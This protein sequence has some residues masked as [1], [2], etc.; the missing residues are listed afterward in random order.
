MMV[1]GELVVGYEEKR[2]LYRNTRFADILKEAEQL[3]CNNEF[4]A[5]SIVLDGLRSKNELLERLNEKIKAKPFFKYLK[6]SLAGKTVNEY[7]ELKAYTSFATHVAIE[8]EK[9]NDEY[10]FL[11]K[12]ILGNI[13][14]LSVSKELLAE[15]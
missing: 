4:N 6:R 10:R 7:E 1:M 8:C 14:E 12:K 2:E 9:G 15:V 5:A 11:L 13:N 3:M